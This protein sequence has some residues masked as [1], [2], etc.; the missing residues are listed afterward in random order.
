[1]TTYT[2]PTNFDVSARF[3]H[4]APCAFAT[5]HYS[6]NMHEANDLPQDI[7]SCHELIRAQAEQI[8]EQSHLHEEHAHKTAQL[9]DELEKM[10]RVLHELMHGRR[11]EKRVPSSPD[12]QWL[13]FEDDAEYLAARA[14]AEAEAEVVIQTFTVQREVRKRKP[15]SESFPDHLRREEMVAVTPD[16]VLHCATHGDRTLVGYDE[17]HTLVYKP[18]DLYV[19]VTKYPKYACT[20]HPDCGI[21]SPERPTSLVEG[22]RYDTSVAATIVEAKWF[23]YL[24]IYRHQDLF[25]GAGW[26]PSRSTLLNIVQQVE[27]VIDPLIAYMKQRVQQDMGVGLDDTSCRLLIPKV[28]PVVAAGDLKTQ[29]LL[30][31]IAEAG[32]KGEDSLMAKMWVYSGLHHAP[33]NIFDFRVSRHRD[34]PDE[35]LRDS[36]CLVQADC[37][38]GNTSVIVHSEGRLEF[39]ACW[40]HARRKVKQA[41][42]HRTDADT[43]EAMIHALYD[44]E[45]RGK[46]LSWEARQE[47]RQRESTVVLRAIEKWLDSAPLAMILPKSDFAEAVRYIRNHWEALNAYA[48]DGRVPIDNNAVEQLMKQVALG[49]KAWLFMG[50][51]EAGERSAKMMTL[52]SSARRHDLNVWVYI[53]D[54]LDRLLAG[55]TDYRQLLPDVWKLSHPDAV[56]TYREQER[57]DK[58]DRKQLR[59]AQRRLLNRRK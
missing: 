56:R 50:T 30:E 41:Q 36:H 43:L 38:S 4:C 21:S 8:A 19:L 53:K 44:I 54:V 20:G 32:A 9:Q 25:A 51:V 42:T 49:R 26:M 48:R 45:A 34:G 2:G 59:A 15:R 46:E 6:T 27:F 47:L 10:R 52:A 55:E 39:V 58:A 11:S 3:T 33:Y 23:Y 12:Q 18:A 37:F 35:F 22:N 7:Q 28:L 29:R 57:Q 1:M 17:T 16:S 14:E 40:A 24:P 5:T 31:K 13:P